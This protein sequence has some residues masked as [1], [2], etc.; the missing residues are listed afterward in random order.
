MIG[1]SVYGARYTEYFSNK[2]PG[3]WDDVGQLSWAF[4]I[5]ITVCVG[6]FVSFLLVLIEVLADYTQIV[7]SGGYPQKY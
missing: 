2:E 6:S 5:A 1:V 3:R 7:G 4:A